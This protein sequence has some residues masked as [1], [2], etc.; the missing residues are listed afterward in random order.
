MFQTH[1]K[2]QSSLLNN[3][4]LD[5]ELAVHKNTLNYLMAL[6]LNLHLRGLA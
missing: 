5:L 6:T 1:S 2:I 3:L 4:S